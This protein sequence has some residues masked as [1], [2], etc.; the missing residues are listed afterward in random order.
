VLGDAAGSHAGEWTV[1]FR[2]RKPDELKKWLHSREANLEAALAALQK[3]TLPYSSVVH[4]RSN[5][6]FAAALRQDSL[7]PGA[8]LHVFA[9]LSEYGVPLSTGATV[10]ADLIRPDG[11]TTVLKLN[12]LEPG[13]HTLDVPT[14]SA[15]IYRLRVRAEGQ[16]S[17][18]YSFTREKTLS[19][20]VF[21][22]GNKRPGDGP[23]DGGGE[24]LCELLKCLLSGEVLDKRAVER[25]KKAGIDSAALKKCLAQLCYDQRI[26]EPKV[27]KPKPV[28]KAARIGKSKSPIREPKELFR[29]VAAPRLLARPVKEDAKARQARKA[30]ALA[31]HLKSPFPPLLEGEHEGHHNTRSAEPGTTPGHAGP[32]KRKP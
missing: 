26:E 25:L 23:A 8:Q 24:T 11:S 16:T 1:V 5:L 12:R 15:G 6:D 28:V 22:G 30:A 2:L 9:R 13:R 14:S 29:E 21:A 3:G 4:T 32:H 19:A 27:V 31:A 18:G 10:W 20:G 7:D 17:G